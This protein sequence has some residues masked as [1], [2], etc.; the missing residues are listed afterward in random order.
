[1]GHD[2][3]H[4]MV[5][6]M[7]SL[8]SYISNYL[9]NKASVEEKFMTAATLRLVYQLSFGKRVLNLG[10]GNGIVARSLDRICESQH[11]VEGSKL[12]IDRFSFKSE[13]TAFIH[14]FFE[15]FTSNRDFDLILANHVLEHVDDPVNI[16]NVL[17]DKHCR[18]DTILYATV[19]NAKSMHRL[20]GKQMGMLDSVYSLNS[21]D[22]RAGHQRVYDIESLKSHFNQSPFIITDLGGYNLKLVSLAQMED[23]SDELLNAIFEVSQ[24]FPPDICS[25][26]WVKAKLK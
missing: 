26:I 5:E 6:P 7:H 18:A 21:S 12:I 22:V 25:N 16:L 3:F 1:M 8:D 13:R 19:P 24:D 15:D 23:W 11:V 9:G 2:I 17:A 10:L 14:S 4:P 20:I